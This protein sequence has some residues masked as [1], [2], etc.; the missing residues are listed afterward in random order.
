MQTKIHDQ[1]YSEDITNI[2][3]NLEQLEESKNRLIK[4]NPDQLQMF[5][6][7]QKLRNI[8]NTSKQRYM[9]DNRFSVSN[10]TQMLQVTSINKGFKPR[11]LVRI[12]AI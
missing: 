10:E 5:K 9:T 7:Q 3:Y 2:N 11:P 4:N 8:M 6:E 12:P 1:P